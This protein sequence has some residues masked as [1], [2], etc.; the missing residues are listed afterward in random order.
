MLYMNTGGQKGKYLPELLVN[1]M[2]NFVR[3]NKSDVYNHYKPFFLVV[4][5]PAPRSAVAGADEFPVPSDAPYTDEK[6]PQAAKNRASLITRVDGGIGRLFA[7]FREIGLSNNV[8]I[9]FT[10]SEAPEKFK[11][12]KMN[13]LSPNGKAVA[14]THGVAAPLPMI[15]RWPEG[16]PAGQ[17]SGFKWSDVDLMPTVL[18]MS[19]T[20]TKKD[21]DGMSI[22]PVLHGVHGPDVDIPA[23][24]HGGRQF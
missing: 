20:K 10:S 19:Y 24:G 17:V 21:Y 2:C 15:V 14:G 22:L 13:F 5:F 1:A 3:I 12:P 23:D 18:Q 8:A 16:I 6:W 11:D 4:N 9:F 7:Q